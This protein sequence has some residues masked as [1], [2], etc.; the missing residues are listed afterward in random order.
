MNNNLRFRSDGTF[1]IVQFTDLHWKNGDSEDK[2]TKALMERVLAEEQPDLI[3]LTGDVIES[4]SCKDPIRSYR[5]ALSVVEQSG[6]PWA[7]VFGNHDCEGKTT[8]EQLINVQLEHVGTITEAGPLE[9][10]GVGNFVAKVA[11][12]N[13]ETGAALYFLDSGGYSDIPSV[14]GYDWIRQSQ[15]EWFQKQA[16]T[17][18]TSNGGVPVPALVFFHIPLPEYREIWNYNVCYGHRH[19]KVN[20]PKVNSGFFAAMVEAGGVM[21]TFCGHDHTN[22]Y[23]GMLRGIQLSYG[24]ATGYNTYGKWLYQRGARVIKLRLG[25]P[26]TSWIRLANG[27]KVT[28]F[29]K[30]HPNWLSRG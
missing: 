12:S 16:L 25:Q 20:C 15:I 21:G 9:V 4:L 30:H 10:D 14:P 23:T 19:E 28:H 6:I 29:H 5:E 24:R 1:T 13:G 27:H 11:D 2:R 26:Y 8:R 18:Q 22:D 17:L 7:A 3:V